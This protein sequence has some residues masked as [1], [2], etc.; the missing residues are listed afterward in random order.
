MSQIVVDALEVVD[1]HYKKRV[2]VVR[3]TAFDKPRNFVFSA[4]FV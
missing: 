3:I 2:S 4:D 1:V